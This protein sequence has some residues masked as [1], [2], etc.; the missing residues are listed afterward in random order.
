MGISVRIRRAARL[1]L[2]FAIA[3]SPISA[4]ATPRGPYD[5]R[6]PQSHCVRSADALATCQSSGFASR[7]GSF[8]LDLKVISTLNGELPGA[9][10]LDGSVTFS[11]ILPTIKGRVPH[12]RIT[13]FIDQAIAEATNTLGAANGVID[14]TPFRGP[15]NEALLDYQINLH[16]LC[17]CRS[18]T[19]FDDYGPMM[20]VSSG[21]G[22]VT[23][24]HRALTI[25]ASDENK[26][27][28]GG[29]RATF[30]W[31]GFARVGLGMP[32]NGFAHLA[33]HG[34]LLRLTVG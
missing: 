26:M 17:S 6:V 30:T 13:L 33:I 14:K 4:G 24:R 3:L 18:D 34:W 12:V 27:P 7:N 19:T 31:Y 21:D 16:W 22:T 23:L 9:G 10:N 32:S 20:D 1:I 25:D 5:A 29:V 28:A 8:N 2:V 15:T 11:K